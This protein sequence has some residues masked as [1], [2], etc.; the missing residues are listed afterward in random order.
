MFISSFTL[1]NFMVVC[2]LKEKNRMYD[3]IGNDLSSVVLVHGCV[4]YLKK[5]YI[6]IVYFSSRL[7][8]LLFDITNA[9][10]S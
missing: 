8:R 9:R 6:G 2:E 5:K 3:E 10:C 7:C 4:F 1:Q